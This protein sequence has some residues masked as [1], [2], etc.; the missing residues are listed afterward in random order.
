MNALT[1]RI[2]LLGLVCHVVSTVPNADLTATTTRKE[3]STS[4][5]AGVIPESAAGLQSELEAILRAVK[6][7]N[8]KQFDDLVNDLQIPEGANWFAAP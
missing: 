4:Q 2:G 3:I 6:D 8:P 5:T 1:L 7:R